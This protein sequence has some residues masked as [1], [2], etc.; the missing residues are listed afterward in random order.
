MCSPPGSA[1]SDVAG[2][3]M[4]STW[5][6]ENVLF[7]NGV[8]LFGDPVFAHAL[9]RL[10]D[11]AQYILAS[12][13]AD[14][15]DA[16]A[17]GEV[18]AIASEPTTRSCNHRRMEGCIGVIPVMEIGSNQW[19]SMHGVVSLQATARPSITRDDEMLCLGLFA[20]R[21]PSKSHLSNS[22]LH[23]F[24]C[25]SSSDTFTNQKESCFAI[26]YVHVRD[27]SS[28]TSSSASW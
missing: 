17:N 7:N 15:D 18:R 8:L 20:P 4:V 27:V 5:P 14:T 13:V 22:P 16:G 6:V 12:N 23:T 11:L 25:S 28:Q 24:P 1:R 2:W 19:Y 26:G 3:T 9:P 21:R 10:R